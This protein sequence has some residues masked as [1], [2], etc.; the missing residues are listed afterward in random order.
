MNRRNDFRECG[1]RGL[2]LRWS[3]SS[4]PFSVTDS[5]NKKCGFVTALVVVIVLQ[6]SYLERQGEDCNRTTL[7]YEII[8]VVL[9]RIF[10]MTVPAV[11]GK[12]ASSEAATVQNAR[13]EEM[14]NVVL[15]PSRSNRASEEVSE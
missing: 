5:L 11:A 12:G 7:W 2:A 14:T 10:K 3:R 15:L 1:H 6:A 8:A 4:P 9:V 13:A